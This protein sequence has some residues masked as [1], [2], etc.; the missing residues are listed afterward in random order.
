M[1]GLP[2]ANKPKYS[3]VVRIQKVYNK[4][5]YQ[6]FIFEL[7]TMLAR[8]PDKK[9]S[10]LMHHL[11]HG[12]K[13]AQPKFIYE[14]DSGLDIRFANAGILGQGIYF[15]NNSGY[16]NRYCY[17]DPAGVM[18]QFLC[19]VLVGDT[20]G[21]NSPELAGHHVNTATRLPPLKPGSQVQRYDSVRN[22]A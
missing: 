4:L 10:E 2:G 18:Q 15:S 20:V 13:Q 6:K 21:H 16:S 5:V 8:Y 3:Q 7:Q 14:S 17:N 11:Y 22:I 19:L 9:I 12:S 1:G